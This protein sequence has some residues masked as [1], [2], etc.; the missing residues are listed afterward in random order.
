MRSD[1]SIIPVTCI[2]RAVFIVII[3][4][5]K[6]DRV[7]ARDWVF[8]DTDEVLD[9]GDACKFRHNNSMGTCQSVSS[10]PAAVLEYRQSKI[11]PTMCSLYPKRLIVCCSD[12]G[13]TKDGSS[14]GAQAMA[15]TYSA[16]FYCKI[17]NS[18]LYE[19]I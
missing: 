17:V 6:I 13:Q 14:D 10:C 3:M 5:N 9:L 12:E 16:S 18:I 7:A 19:C 1:Y 4:C 11:I 2:F 15:I 8:S